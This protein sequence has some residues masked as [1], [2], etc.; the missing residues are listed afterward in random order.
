MK[1]I[2]E[3]LIGLGGVLGEVDKLFV[4][5]NGPLVGRDERLVWINGAFVGR[6]R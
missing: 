6:D 3:P 1:G 5:G 4:E 2:Q